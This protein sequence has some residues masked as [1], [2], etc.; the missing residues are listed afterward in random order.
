MKTM[1]LA[2]VEEWPYI[3]LISYIQYYD[4]SLDEYRKTN[5]NTNIYFE[6][7]FFFLEK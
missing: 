6:S 4:F 1:K 2:I 5:T 3:A 7:M